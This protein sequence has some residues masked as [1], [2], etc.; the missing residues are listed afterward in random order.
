MKKKHKKG[1]NI[2][3]IKEIL[4]KNKNYWNRKQKLIRTKKKD[5]R[6]SQIKERKKQTKVGKECNIRLNI[7]S[8]PNFIHQ[9]AK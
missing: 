1:I 2:K 6:R 8:W 3:V 9:R 4:N 5:F 7:S